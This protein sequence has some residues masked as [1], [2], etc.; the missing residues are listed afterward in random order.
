MSS[1]LP[2]RPDGSGIE[3]DTLALA[4][5]AIALG[6]FAPLAA[7]ALAALVRSRR[8]PWL[9]LTCLPGG[10]R[11]VAAG[12]SRGAATSPH[13]TGSIA[14]SAVVRCICSRCSP[15]SCGP[16]GWQR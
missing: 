8:N 5:L 9:W 2:P 6:P 12:R 16:F 11:C 4:F 1:P 14:A 3:L 10:R 15:P 7:A 13:S